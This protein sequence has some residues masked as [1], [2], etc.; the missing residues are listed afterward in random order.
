MANAVIYA[1]YSSS[2]QREESI[3]DQVRVCT[4]AASRA[5]DRILRVYADKATS[6]T[7][8]EHRAEFARM[9]AESEGA[10]WSKVYVYKTDR[11]ARNRYDSAVYKAKLKRNGV[12]VV[13]ATESIDDGPDG[14]LL[15]ALLEGMAEYYS[16]N[17]AQNTKRGMEGNAL[18]CKHNGV[19]LFGYDLGDDGYYRVNEQEGRAVRE[20]YRMYL[21]GAGMPEIVE[22]LEPYRT[23]RGGKLGMPHVSRM[24]RNEKY[25]GVYSFGGVRVEGGMPAIVSKGEFDDVQA[26]LSSRTRRRRDKVD[27]VLTGRLFDASGNRY[28]G[29]SGKNHDGVKYA[30]YKCAETSHAMPKEPLEDAVAGV[31]R[32][33]LASD[34][35]ADVVADLVLEYQERSSSDTTEAIKAARKRMDETRREERRLVELAS[36]TGNIDEIARRIDELAGE[37]DRLAIDIAELEASAPLFTRDHVLRWMRNVVANADPLK[38]VQMFVSK[39]VVDPETGDLRVEFVVGDDG[40]GGGGG[41]KAPNP[42]PDCPDEGST[43]LQMAPRTRVKSNLCAYATNSG[44]G[45]LSFRI[46]PNT[47]D[48]RR[49]AKA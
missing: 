29:H 6:G 10:A 13:S 30:Y 35:V 31:V 1:R 9:V 47:A 48:F 37:R 27:Y 40:D 12:R 28:S 23:H 3:E 43:K 4:E 22:M 16:A 14:I 42:R 46:A 21:Q 20:A 39:V 24:L 5:G 15:E 17:L 7:S 38:A 49:R 11:F 2:A 8:T 26:L 41:G 33:F 44:F 32:D 25:A 45:L 19:S 34:H 18:K 36:K